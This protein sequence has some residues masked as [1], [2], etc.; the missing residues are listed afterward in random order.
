MKTLVNFCLVL[1][2]FIFS[3]K[4]TACEK[5]TFINKSQIKIANKYAERFCSAKSDHFFEGLENETTLKNSYFEFI[6]LRNEEIFSKE[7]LKPL[8]NQIRIK[9]DIS[10][11]EEIEI[12]KFFIDKLQQVQ[13]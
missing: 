8:I 11:E 2:F 3:F 6:G 12:N 5:K 7:M 4:V 9:C 13:K 1:F 10:N